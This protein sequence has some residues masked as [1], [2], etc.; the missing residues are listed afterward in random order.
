MKFKFKN[1][2]VLHNS[3]DK[4]GISAVLSS[5]MFSKIGAFSRE[6]IYGKMLQLGLKHFSI[7]AF[8]DDF[9]I[10]FHVLKDKAMSALQFISPA[11]SD[12]KFSKN[13][14]EY[15]KES[16][17]KVLD[18][19]SHP[20]ELLFEKLMSSLYED[21]NYGFSNTGTGKA[22]S[23][24]TKDDILNFMKAKFSRNNLEVLFAG[25]ISR[26]DVCNYLEI[27]FTKLPE[28]T[29]EK[30]WDK[31]E[32][33]LSQEK[34]IT[35]NKPDM[36]DIVGVMTGV[37]IDELSDM[38]KAAACVIIEYLYNDK[39]GNFV[40]NL[41]SCNIAYSVSYTLLARSLSNVFY[42]YVFI[43]KNDLEKYRKFL[44][45]CIDF[46]CNRLNLK[47]L[48]RTQNYFIEQTNNGF[49]DL[50]DIDEK[51][52]DRLLPFEKINQRILKQ[53]MNKLFNK[54]LMRTIIIGDNLTH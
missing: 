53:V 39:I 42:F 36:K 21:H 41:R 6:E 4:H 24:I 48:T 2:G 18:I 11:F 27:L 16:F 50:T 28:T 9:E 38:E 43:E 12:P 35:I 22:I 33:K 32:A 13:D 49:A 47:N 25:D 10:S 51:N 45:K 19:D 17:P 40:Q 31:I 46:Y 37:R 29:S 15:A 30:Q 14:L 44:D 1:A 54:S 8:E 20:R 3:P 26:S 52:K 7:N 34:I 5:F 23:S